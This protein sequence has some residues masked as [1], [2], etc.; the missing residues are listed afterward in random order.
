[1]A[2]KLALLALLLALVGCSSISAGII[3]DK[4]YSPAY[5]WT[6]MMCVGK[7]IVCY[8]IIHYVP[9]QWSF[10]LQDGKGTEGW[11]YVSQDEFN[12]YEVGDYYG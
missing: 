7:P 12:K 10:S 6:Q 11:V 2:K 9:E 5:S 1:M 8:P 3:T 4:N